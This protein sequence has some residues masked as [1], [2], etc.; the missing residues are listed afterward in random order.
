MDHCFKQVR[1]HEL[2]WSISSNYDTNANFL[3]HATPF[4]AYWD[5]FPQLSFEDLTSQ[6]IK[7]LVI[8]I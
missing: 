3:V 4:I 8:L 2:N 7:L 6:Q 5:P 1:N